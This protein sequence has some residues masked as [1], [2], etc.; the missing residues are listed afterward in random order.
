M[1]KISGR[2]RFW[3]GFPRLVRREAGVR[4]RRRASGRLHSEFSVPENE[5]GLCSFAP[6]ILK[7]EIERD[8]RV[9]FRRM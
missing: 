3:L 9:L 5:P 4:R 7:L 6:L 2:F 8:I 1:H